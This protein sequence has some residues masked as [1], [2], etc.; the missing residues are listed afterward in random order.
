MYFGIAILRVPQGLDYSQIIEDEDSPVMM[1]GNDSSAMQT[2]ED[3][4]GQSSSN[5]LTQGECV[6]STNISLQY[7]AILLPVLLRVQINSS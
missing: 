4:V 1:N 2:L 5:Q 3:K 7:L 6:M